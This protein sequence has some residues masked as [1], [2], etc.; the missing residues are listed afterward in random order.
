M[1]WWNPAKAERAKMPAQRTL[2]LYARQLSVPL[3]RRTTAALLRLLLLAGV[4]SMV[5]S[6]EQ[7]SG[8]SRNLVLHAVLWGCLGVLAGQW[9]GRIVRASRQHG[10]VTV[11]LLSP[12]GMVDTVSV[13]AVPVAAVAGAGADAWIAAVVWIVKVIPPSYRL[14]QLGRV[15]AIE[16]RALGSVAA[17]FVIVLM[18]SAAALHVIEGGVQ[19]DHFGTMPR[20]LW[21]AVTTLTTTGYGDAVPA[22]TPG[23]IVAGFTMVAGLGVF[24]LWTGIL[25]TGF[26]A[27]ARRQDF[28][29]SWEAVAHVPFF[30][31]LG[32]AAITELARMLRPLDLPEGAVVF[33][34]G[35]HGESMYFI[36]AGEVE[37]AV[38]PQPVCLGEG[39]FF[40]EM[41]LLGNGVRSATVITRRP[42]T[43]LVLDLADFHT[44][45]A[46]HPSLAEAVEAEARRRGSE[47]THAPL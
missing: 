33:R 31:S 47:V 30:S 11:Y 12:T 25:A 20:S 24:G 42:S 29:R 16:A 36:V 23:R 35:R 2:R 3:R 28:L 15:I 37:V 19:P 8:P 13:F 34:R 5:L 39:D 40:G 9:A 4:I 32:P 18:L 22:T 17:L 41:A 27:V 45:A 44:L 6:T 26:T 1:H 14:T 21:W 43:L 7:G 38:A 46:R 10:G